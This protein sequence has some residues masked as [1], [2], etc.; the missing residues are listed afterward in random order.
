MKQRVTLLILIVF[1]TITSTAQEVIEEEATKNALRLQFLG[2]AKS[3]LGLEY[4]RRIGLQSAILVEAG[5]IG[6]NDSQIVDANAKGAIGG[7]GIKMYGKNYYLRRKQNS[8]ASILGGFYGTAR[9]TFEN[10][11]VR[12]VYSAYNINTG[13]IT[14]NVY[15]YER[16]LGSGMLGIGINFNIF[17]N[18]TLDLG[19]MGGFILLNNGYD[20]NV[21]FSTDYFEGAYHH[22]F[23]YAQYILPY[24]MRGY[25]N[26]GVN[27]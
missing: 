18:I 3:V 20:N 14:T 12:N 4:E 11:S 6:L 8:N 24:T 1:S 21:L 16:N 27:F 5:Y 23:V 26:I 10:Y 9:L 22:G 13:L 19:Y 15:S 17:K 2:P 25:I 7:L